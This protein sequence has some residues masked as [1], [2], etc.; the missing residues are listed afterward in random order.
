MAAVLKNDIMVKY[1][2]GFDLAALI[3]LCGIFSSVQYTLLTTK[4][5]SLQKCLAGKNYS[6]QQSAAIVKN[7]S[8]LVYNNLPVSLSRRTALDIK[9][10]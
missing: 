1:R 8:L 4:I 5:F 3:K 6:C 2:H 10:H 7:V 9:W